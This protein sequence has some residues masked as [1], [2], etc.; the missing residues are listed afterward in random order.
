MNGM[1]R[2]RKPRV[3]LALTLEL[4][5]KVMSQ[6]IHEVVSRMEE[7]E[8]VTFFWGEKEDY[9]KYYPKRFVFGDTSRTVIGASRKFRLTNYGM[10]DAVIING[11]ELVLVLRRLISKVPCIVFSDTVPAYSVRVFR[12]SGRIKNARL[13]QFWHVVMLQIVPKVERWC[14]MTENLASVLRDTLGILPASIT[15][16]RPGID[17]EVWR[18]DPAIRAD[19]P[20]L[21]FV[22]NDFIRKGGDFLCEV[23][24]FLQLEH[25]VSIISNDAK[26]LSYKDHGRVKVVRGLSHSDLLELI[27]HYQA[28]WLFVFP[29]RFDYFPNV[30]VEAAACGLPTV[31]RDIG[32]VGEAVEH[33]GSGLLMSYH[34]TPEEWAEAIQALIADRERLEAYGRRARQLAEERFSLD[35]LRSQ[36]REVVTS[37]IE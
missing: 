17:L 22:G 13:S 7:I 20:R 9:Q 28:S 23:I 25:E 27:R 8:P 18:P 19:I 14:P 36:I 26:A 6:R 35:R 3:L 2:T 33:E 10:V 12:A 24:R 4:G 21:L 32:A 29:T 5:N 37:L 11:W 34:S 30:L 1:S 16:V 31:A 15:V